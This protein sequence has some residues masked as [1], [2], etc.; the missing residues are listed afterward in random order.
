MAAMV[1][2]PGLQGFAPDEQRERGGEQCVDTARDAK[3]RAMADAVADH[4]EE[5]GE[6]RAEPDQGGEVHGFCTEP[7]VSRM[8][9]PR[10]GASISNAHEVA[11]SAVWKRKLRTEKGDAICENHLQ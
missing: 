8:Y 11:R 7:V 3:Q 1:N 6:Q 5:R 10:I 2:M 9:Q 4:A